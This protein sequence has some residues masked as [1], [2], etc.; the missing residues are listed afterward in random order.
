M[1]TLIPIYDQ[2]GLVRSVILH[3][4][5]EAVTLTPEDLSELRFARREA[6]E[7][8]KA[9]AGLLRK[10][11][12][13]EEQAADDT[14][15]IAELGRLATNAG[16]AHSH[17]ARLHSEAQARIHELEVQVAA[18]EKER[19]VLRAAFAIAR[20]L[21]AVRVDNRDE[22]HT[23]LCALSDAAHAYDRTYKLPSAHTCD[24]C[25]QPLDNVTTG[26]SI[27]T[28]GYKRLTVCADC[29]TALGWAEVAR[30]R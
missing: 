13:L 24:R 7:L 27:V 28:D 14:A 25:Q 5:D 20:R 18:T 26:I 11:R 8:I 30:A 19:S 10:I 2:L 16:Q 22:M 29:R 15:R 6:D 1:T 12:E 17:I 4:G 3:D 9:R 23:R 21:L